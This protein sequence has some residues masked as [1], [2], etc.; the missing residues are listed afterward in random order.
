SLSVPAAGTLRGTVGTGSSFWTSYFTP[1]ASP[2]TLANVGDSLTVRWVF[3]PTTVNNGNTSQGFNLALANSQ[4]ATRL[5]AD[6]SPAAGI[7]S[8]YSMFMNMGQTLSNNSPF[9]LREWVLAG[10]GNLL[11]TAANWGAN[12]VASANLGNGATTGNHGY[13]SG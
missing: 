5:T 6:G 4:S 9:A 13:D 12:G 11:G 7:F 2:I 8:G 1:A 10:S 3:T